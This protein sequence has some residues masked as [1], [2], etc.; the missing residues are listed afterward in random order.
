MKWPAV[1]AV[2]RLPRRESPTPPGELSSEDVAPA[3]QLLSRLSVSFAGLPTN[4]MRRAICVSS[5]SA[6][7]PIV[8]LVARPE[9]RLSGIAIAA[10]DTERF[11]RRLFLRH[12]FLAL[13]VLRKRWRLRTAGTGPSPPSRAPA[14]GSW[15]E[16][17]PRIGKVLFIGVSPDHRSRGL[18]GR[19]Y[20]ELMVHLARRGV[21]RVDARI[22]ARNAASI[23]LHD[24]TGWT[25][26]RDED[27]VFATRSLG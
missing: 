17:G 4:A 15:L 22:H 11:W 13:A 12:P 25:L 7:M 10:Y 24:R 18:A 21:T 2:T 26:R 8:V 19:M 5:L 23:R 1:S 9:G 27:A 14:G 20:G 6:S 16:A 3:V